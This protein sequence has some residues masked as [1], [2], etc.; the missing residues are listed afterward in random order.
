M[1]RVLHIAIAT[2]VLVSLVRINTKADTEN[3]PIRA[4]KEE[5]ISTLNKDGKDWY[6]DFN[7]ES[8]D[9]SLDTNKFS[10]VYLTHWTD[11]ERAKANY[12]LGGDKIH[13]MIDQNQAR[14]RDGTKQQIS[15]IQTG[16]RDGLHI[17]DSSLDIG[18][19]P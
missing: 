18:R 5:A 19:T 1:K 6:L 9:D 11:E 17:F 3:V 8:N 15:S 10:D 14:W 4:D 7:E 16:M 12:Y 13:L 2:L